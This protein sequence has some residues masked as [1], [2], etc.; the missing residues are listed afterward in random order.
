MSRRRDEGGVPPPVIEQE[1]TPAE[2]TAEIIPVAVLTEI[3]APGPRK[4]GLAMWLPLGW[5]TLVFLAAVLAPVLPLKDPLKSDFAN[6][7]VGI[8][9]GGHLLGTDEIGRDILSR[10]VWGSRVALTVGLVAV[11]A[12]MLIGGAIGMLAGYFRGKSETLLMSVVDTM[13]AFPALVLVIAVTAFLGQS[14]RNVT[15]AVAIVAIPAFGRVTRG[16]T[17]TFAQRDFVTAARAMGATN[18]RILLREV[19]P[20]VV[21][22]VAAFALV[23][24]AVAI[25]AEGGLAFLGLSVPKPKPSWGS[26]IAGGV[27][28]LE[29]APHISMI[30]SVVLFL[31]VLS[32]NLVGE[33][34]RNFFDVRGAA[35]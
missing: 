34:F 1:A 17:L 20:N 33:R 5:I 18:K 22:P 24:V 8:G 21:L 7:A 9:K 11:A 29:S 30:P 32:F 27:G 15:I 28:E 12:G 25:V 10:L 35:L 26:M 19:L 2:S 13:L 31:T 23:V 3:T 4:L 16:A 14:L 6:V